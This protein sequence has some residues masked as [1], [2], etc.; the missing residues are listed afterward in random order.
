MPSPRIFVKFAS[1]F[2]FPPCC[3]V[4]RRPRHSHTHAR[5]NRRRWLQEGSYVDDITMVLVHLPRLLFDMAA[6][7]PP[8]RTTTRRHSHSFSNALDPAHPEGRQ[9]PSE[10]A[11]LSAR[12]LNQGTLEADKSSTELALSWHHLQQHQHQHQPQLQPHHR[13]KHPHSFASLGARRTRSEPPLPRRLSNGHVSAARP[14]LQDY[15][16]AQTLLRNRVRGLSAAKKAASASPTASSLRSR[17][18][19]SIK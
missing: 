16:A 18:N 10:S 12:P 11:A 5:V 1:K 15:I 19:P 9:T 6:S 17:N 7:L 8:A 2:R 4:P 14:G 3:C 13:A